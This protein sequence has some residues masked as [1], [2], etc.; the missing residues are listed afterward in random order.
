LQWV[1]KRDGRLAAF[2]PDKI[3]RALFAA[4][5]R[6][7][8]PDPFLARELTDG[9]L[10][11]LSAE[12]PGPVV[13][14]EQIGELVVKVVREL[15]QPALA[16]A[17]E[18]GQVE[19]T[20]GAEPAAVEEGS[21]I[22]S[23]EAACPDAALSQSSTGWLEQPFSPAEL[24]WRIAAP[25]LRRQALA[26]IFS[27]DLQAAQAEGLL[28][29]GGLHAPLEMAAC[30]LHLGSEGP[31]SLLPALEQARAVAG[32]F[33]AVDVPEFL[34]ARHRY[35][36]EA[37]AGFVRA[38]S[39]GLSLAN[40]V[41]VLNLN[42][43]PP[44]SGGEGV[45]APLFEEHFPDAGQESLGPLRQGLLD[46]ALD[47][48]ARSGR[49]RI[50]WHLQ[51]E[52]FSPAG[53]GGLQRLARRVHEGAPL[54][55]VLDR[56]RQ[57]VWLAEGLDRRHPALLMEVGVCLPRLLNQAGGRWDAAEFVHKVGSLARLALSAGTQK[58]DFL[59]R[60]AGQRPLVS[61]GF[62]LD[63]ARLKVVPLGLE[64]SVRRVLGAGA[65]QE[66][67]TQLARQVVARLEHVLEEDGRGRLLDTCVGPAF[68]SLDFPSPGGKPAAWGGGQEAA[69]LLPADEPPPV[70][71]IVEVL[72]HAWRRPE[73]HRVQWLPRHSSSLQI[74]APWET[75]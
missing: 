29:L 8:R 46:A 17:F 16:R 25:V 39:S 70:E 37:A 42:C 24:A 59:R 7:G 19:R 13:S 44:T 21:G 75:S 67:I 28:V 33:L 64:E 43:S 32:T 5:E 9:I 6:L 36:A 73:I 38:L 47:E 52:D 3:S 68:P 54:A 34:L 56:A 45:P 61:A 31:A 15:G 23:A 62:L 55:F 63:R 30:V 35:R 50:G 18:E 58:R 51:A 72:R 11:F 65:G 48:R 12:K 71:S 53:L 26:E 20:R 60:R 69:L 41:A 49:L 66:A 10:H 40:L 74:T 1:R 27:R 22:E 14:A 2:E 57:P 4:G